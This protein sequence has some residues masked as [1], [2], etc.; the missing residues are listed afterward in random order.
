MTLRSWRE[1]A[2]QALVFEAGGLLIATPVYAFISG[3]SSWSSAGLLAA[4]A[5]AAAFGAALHNAVFD[6]LDLHLTGR[7]ASDR[8]HLLR[9]LHAFTHE[10]GSI[11]VT[12]PVI[13]WV[14]GHGL[15]EALALDL[16]LSALYAVYAYGF[17]W[18]YDQLRPVRVAS[19]PPADPP[20]TWPPRLEPRPSPALAEVAPLPNRR[21]P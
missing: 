9:L 17:Y 12:L 7:P 13:V 5:V 16:G 10:L 11:V 1:R 4:V 20:E 14:G 2:V 8:P 15:A 3:K 6:G 21:R 18:A 19:P